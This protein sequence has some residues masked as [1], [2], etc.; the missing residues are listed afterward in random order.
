VIT[1]L[2]FGVPMPVQPMKLIASVALTGAGLTAPQ[3]MAAGLFVGGAVLLLGALGLM[4]LATRLMPGAIVRGMQLGLGLQLASK[5]ALQVWF[6]DGKAAP[7]RGWWGAEGLFLG[8]FAVAFTLL[9]VYPM[10]PR[11][12]AAEE[13]EDAEEL[14]ELKEEEGFEAAAEAA[15]GKAAEV[16]AAEV[17]ADP[18]PGGG[19]APENCGAAGAAPAARRRGWRAALRAAPGVAQLYALGAAGDVAAGGGGLGAGAPLAGCACAPPRRRG[20]FVPAALVLV[21]IGVALAMI[22]YPAALSSLALG[23]AAIVA[24]MPSAADWRVGVLRAG[25]PQ[26]SLTVFNS[27]VSVTALAGALFPA[28]APRAGAV[29]MSVGAMNLVGCWLGAMPA[30]HGA[31]GLAGQVRFGARS[32][33]A[34]IFLGLI[35][36]SLGLLLGS[37]LA[38]LVASFPVPI[39]GAMLVF[40]GVELAAVARGQVGERGAAVMLATAAVT[41]AAQNVAIGVATGLVAAYALAARDTAVRGARAAWRCA[42]A[43]RARMRGAAA[44]SV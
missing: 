44:A 24:T 6:A 5:G 10:P 22:Y 4:G 2:A 43:R 37:S 7:V 8:L 17:D 23:P 19:A 31:G 15:A 41:L 42:R 12:G 38:A 9:T 16:E 35:K 13:G 30:C 1:G 39:L 32:G 27:V 29:A 40:A 14:Q 33:A 20:F 3:V 25:L 26:L 21:A 36:L 18:A 34:P 28:R 11:P